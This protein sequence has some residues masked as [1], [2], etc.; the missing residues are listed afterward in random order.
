[1]TASSLSG[2]FA[3]VLT[4]FD[5]HLAPDVPAFAGFCRWLLSQGAGLAVFGTN[6][7]ANSLSAAE[8]IDLLAALVDA[9]LPPDR[10]MPGTGACALTDAVA[11]CRAA[12]RER[13]AAVLMLP[14]FYY[15]SVSDDGLFAF[16]AET[17]ER[18]GSAD[19]KICLYHIPPIAQVPIP[20][21]LIERLIRHYPETVVGIKDSG[22]DFSHTKAML[23]AFPGFKVFCGSEIF[24]SDTLAHGGAGCISA[25]A[26]VNARAIVRSF[27]QY[28][29]PGEADRQ[30]AL[31]RVRRAYDGVAMIPAL[32]R[33]VAEFGARP[34]FAAVRPPLTPMPDAAWA[35]LS[36]RLAGLDLVL[37]ELP[38][39]LTPSGE[40]SILG[41]ATASG[42]GAR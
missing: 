6:S 29:Q 31:D 41:P 22:G 10:M 14:P 35:A 27:E 28:G 42:R 24:L 9:G 2:V 16:Y 15:K 3:P 33:T 4:P 38:E 8:K 7:E 12:A 30:A 32:K 13:T 36:R 18:V 20:L 19:L 37:P 40:G 17:I 21:T 1:M 26:N 11:L 23:E 5:K 25:L 39:M 34:Q